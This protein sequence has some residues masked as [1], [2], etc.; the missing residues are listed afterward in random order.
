MLVSAVMNLRVPWNAGSFLTSCRTVSFSRRT[1]HHGVSKYYTFLR[2]RDF[3]DVKK[4]CTCR[5]NFYCFIRH[6]HTHCLRN[7]NDFENCTSVFKTVRSYNLW[8]P[9]AFIIG[10]VAKNLQWDG[11]ARRWCQQTSKR[12]GAVTD[13]WFYI[14]NVVHKSWL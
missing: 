10:C 12:I 8:S 14:C 13:M 1:L 6:R 2:L 4:L 5:F 7:F 11:A 9:S 3:Y